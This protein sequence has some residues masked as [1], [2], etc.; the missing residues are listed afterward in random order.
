ML[1]IDA[2]AALYLLAS[3]DGMEPLVGLELMAP[4]LLWSECT[5]VLNEMR[6]RGEVSEALAT[7]AF[8]RLLAAPIARRAEDGIY[9]GAREVAKELGWAKTYD[10]EYVSLAR[11]LG[12]NLLTR[13]ERL[14][15]GAVRL[16]T[17]VAPD[18]VIP[19]EHSAGFE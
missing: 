10:A 5:S 11:M 18:D 12:A 1:V 15:R 3:A 19:P 13:D 14:R 2:S 7:A 9:T 16:V 17:V 4:A 6:R 8:E